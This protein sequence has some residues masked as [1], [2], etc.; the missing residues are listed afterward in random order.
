MLRI[1]SFKI[2]KLY[3]DCIDEDGN[4]FIIY[5]AKVHFF[6]IRFVYSGLIFCDA[7]GLITE[8]STLRKT[9]KPAIDGTIEFNHKLLKIDVSIKRTDDAIIRSLYKEGEKNVLIWNC[10]H[11]KAMAEII[12]NGNIYKGFGYAETLFSQIKP[13]N[14]PIDELKWGRFISDSCTSI[15]ISWMGQYP[16]NKMFSNG[17]EYND[18]IFGNDIIIFGNGTYQLKFSDVKLIR[19]GKLSALFSKMP[20]LKIFLNRRILNT[21]EIKYKAKTTFTKNSAFLSNGWSLFEIVTWGK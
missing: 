18:A 6:L 3:L 9:K 10:H 17:I 13:W 8:K 15:W 20:L 21:I 1:R 7:E 14:L 16:I 11:P 5:W 12:F 2:E 19:K 4:C